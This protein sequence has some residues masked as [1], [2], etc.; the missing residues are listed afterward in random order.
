MYPRLPGQFGRHKA[1]STAQ[2]G[3]SSAGR[4]SAGM[5]HRCLQPM[6]LQTEYG[7]F[8]SSCAIACSCLTI[9]EIKL[10]Q[11]QPQHLSRGSRRYSTILTR[12]IQAHCR[13]LQSLQHAQPAQQSGALSAAPHKA[14][15]GTLPPAYH[16]TAQA[17]QPQV[18]SLQLASSDFTA[19]LST[20]PHI[21][22]A[23]EDLA[24]NSPATHVLTSCNTPDCISIAWPGAAMDQQASCTR[25]SAHTA[26]PQPYQQRLVR[27]RGI[28]LEHFLFPSENAAQ[29]LASAAVALKLLIDIQLLLPVCVILIELII[30]HSRLSLQVKDE[31]FAILHC[32]KQRNDD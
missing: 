11:M 10:R 20:P 2:P 30:E 27:L 25:C 1:S 5:V 13:C 29:A 8:H 32:S 16:Q 26:Q 17:Y 23:G 4:S 3:R 18:L 12:A 19:C 7:I 31:G 6:K 15:A 14:A 28:H 9:N 22:E 24:G 21:E